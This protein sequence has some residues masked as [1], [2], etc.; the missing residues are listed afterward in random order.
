MPIT[1]LRT[2]NTFSNMTR[3]VS[4]HSTKDYH[5][6]MYF[7][8]STGAFGARTKTRTVKHRPRTPRDPR[9]LAVVS[10][11][12]VCAIRETSSWQSD[13]T[14]LSSSVFCDFKVSREKT[15][16]NTKLKTTQTRFCIFSLDV[17]IDI[18]QKQN[19]KSLE[20]DQEWMQLFRASKITR[21]QVEIAWPQFAEQLDVHNQL[22]LDYI[23]H[24]M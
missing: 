18:H 23:A 21:N 13:L 24:Y 20:R 6:P 11:Q 3:L 17:S 9:G 5:S 22:I 19:R 4:K 16:M 12:T 1:R 14:K 8:D 2:W 7:A 10:A 15:A